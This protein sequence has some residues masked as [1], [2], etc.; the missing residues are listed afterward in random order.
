VRV[1]NSMMSRANLRNLNQGLA[2]LQEAQ[3]Q[4]AS[5]KEFT[6]P[7]ED[8]GRATSAM[9]T[10]KDL[11]RIDQRMRSIEDSQGWVG[12]ADT[13]LTS[14][15]DRMLRAKEIAVNAGNGITA[16]TTAARTSLATELRSVRSDLLV[17]ANAT[18]AGRSLFA[19]TAGGAAY[20]PNG[21]FAGNDEAVIRDV[22]PT[23]AMTINVTGNQVFG[24]SGVGAGTLFEV[25]DRMAT[26]IEAGDR[27]AAATEHANLDGA[28]ERLREA[29]A[30]IGTTWTSL[31]QLAL[32][33]QDEKVALGERLSQM[34]D[35]DMVESLIR[36]KSRESSYQ[37]ALQTTAKVM[38]MSLL[39]F[40]R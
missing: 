22:A 33:T 12:A 28:F 10:R 32:R 11:R 30:V 31:E 20:D 29:S 13:Q 3:A 19:G 15:L 26:A 27:A 25:L 38:S 21:Q 34:E 39:D 2:R 8:P 5:G 18:Y 7:S 23:T 36:V 6:K 40:L 9:S 17:V 24:T 37:A 14:A 35:V 1:T 16:L 4:I